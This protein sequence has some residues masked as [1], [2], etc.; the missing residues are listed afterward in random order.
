MLFWV[1]L[2]ST[3]PMVTITVATGQ[4]VSVTTMIY[5]LVAIV[6]FYSSGTIAMRTFLEPYQIGDVHK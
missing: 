6:L 5:P 4:N 2:M 3:V 1:M